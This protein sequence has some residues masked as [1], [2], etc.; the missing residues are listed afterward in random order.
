MCK[1]DQARSEEEINALQEFPKEP[2]EDVITRYI[3]HSTQSNG[4]VHCIYKYGLT[5]HL[6]FGLRSYQ[7]DRIYAN[8]TNSHNKDLVF[9]HFAVFTVYNRYGDLGVLE[10]DYL[11]TCITFEPQTKVPA[12]KKYSVMQFSS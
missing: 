11:A 9:A 10:A 3:Y 12:G 7:E 2:R 1:F 6:I 8:Q 4:F 5:S